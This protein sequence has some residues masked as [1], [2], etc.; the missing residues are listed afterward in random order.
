MTR[1]FGRSGRDRL[2]RSGRDRLASIRDRAIRSGA[3]PATLLV[4][5]VAIA[6]D[7]TVRFDLPPVAAARP[8]IRPDPQPDSTPATE[9]PAANASAAQDSPTNASA[10]VESAAVESA[11]PMTFEL[12]LSSMIA[13]PKPPRIDQWLVTCVPR[14]RSLLIADYAPK[15]ELAGDANGPV[16]VKRIDESTDSIGLSIDGSYG[17]AVKGRAGADH[18]RKSSETVEFQR[19]APVQAVIASGTV[20]RGRGVYFKLRWTS[21]QVLEGEK[22]MRITLAVPPGWRGGL[23]DVSVIAQS[24]R[25]KLAGLDRDVETLGKARFTVAVYRDGDREAER[26]ALALAHAEDELR[27][28]ARATRRDRS[29]GSLSTLLHLVAVKVDPSPDPEPAVCIERLIRGDA[30]PHRDPAIRKLPTNVR[31][32]ALEYDERRESFQTI[33]TGPTM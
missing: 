11:V 1:M 10:A 5:A 20:D 21:Q 33:D 12:R 32:A 13:T 28:L 16:S 8:A 22:T 9:V 17:H 6:G 23:V 25:V 15:T 26:R 29:V 30:D 31:V 3:I 2:G 7:D 19:Q 14:D 18:G 24:E 4:A 27:S